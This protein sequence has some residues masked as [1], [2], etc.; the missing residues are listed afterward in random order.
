MI[1]IIQNTIYLI[2]TIKMNNYEGTK[3][4]IQKIFNKVENSSIVID[5]LKNYNIITKSCSYNTK[6]SIYPIN[7]SLI[8]DDNPIL[9]KIYLENFPEKIL[10]DI[11]IFSIVENSSI[12]NLDK[13]FVP[14]QDSYYCYIYWQGNLSSTLKIN[15]FIS[16]VQDY[17]T[18]NL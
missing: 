7:N 6:Q 9:F 17:N 11:K 16:T 15:L 2:W 8:T 5:R 14:I 12:V 1:N 10:S 4:K 18:I 13:I 3:N